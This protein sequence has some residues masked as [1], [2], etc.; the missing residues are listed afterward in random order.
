MPFNTKIITRLTPDE[1]T[2]TYAACLPDASR[3]QPSLLRSARTLGATCMLGKCRGHRS[4]GSREIRPSDRLLVWNLHTYEIGHNPAASGLGR[5]YSFSQSRLL[6]NSTF[7]PP[8]ES[9]F[10]KVWINGR[11]LKHNLLWLRLWFLRRLSL[12][13]V[14]K[15]IGCT[16]VYSYRWVYSHICEHLYL[17]CISQQEKLTGDVFASA[18]GSCR[19]DFSFSTLM[20]H[21]RKNSCVSTKATVWRT[22]LLKAQ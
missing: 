5:N 2:P 1:Y 20:S 17:Y 13:D 12:S 14:L 15:G 11:I 8:T 9:F 7:E 6:P 10:P 21:Q 16:Y 3:E 22:C 19:V 4:S 18:S